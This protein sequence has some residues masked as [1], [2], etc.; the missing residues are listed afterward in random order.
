MRRCL[1]GVG[2]GYLKPSPTSQAWT[3]PKASYAAGIVAHAIVDVVGVLGLFAFGYGVALHREQCGDGGDGNGDEVAAAVRHAAVDGDHLVE[4]QRQLGSVGALDGKVADQGRVVFRDHGVPGHQEVDD[5]VDGRPAVARLN[6]AGEL[7]SAQV[8]SLPIALTPEQLDKP[9]VLAVAEGFGMQRQIDIG[10]ADV[11]HFRFAQEQPGY[12][13]ADDRELALEAA[14]D[15][16]DLDEDA[17]DRR[18][19]AII[20]VIGGPGFYSIHGS[21]SL[22]RWSAASRSRS[23]PHHRSR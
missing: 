22:A 11:R 8:G 19:G 9:R 5:D 12:G 13:A 18:C 4:I 1:G 14:E 2:T 6:R 3:W 17:L 23:L 20:V 10:G 16:A 21:A 7:E 15:L